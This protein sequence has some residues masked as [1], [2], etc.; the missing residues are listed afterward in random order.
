MNTKAIALD[1]DGTLLDANN[2]IHGDLVK[3]LSE[4]RKQGI[5]LFLVTGRTRDEI[6]HILPYNFPYDG[7]VTSNGMGCYIQDQVMMQQYLNKELVNQLIHLAQEYRVYYELHS[8]ST[9]RQALKTDRKMMEALMNLPAP[10]SLKENE[11]Y[12]RKEALKSEVNWVDQLDDQDVVKIYFFSIELGKMKK[13]KQ[14]L[15][16]LK[17]SLRFSTSS[18]SIHNVEIMN[19]HVNKATGLDVLLKVFNLSGNDLMAIGD[20]ENDLPMFDMSGFSVA[21]NNAPEHVKKQAVTVTRQ[22]YDQHG[23]YLF[24][25]KKRQDGQFHD[26]L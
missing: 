26:P 25:Q 10:D 7:A 12:S 11:R 23:L 8:L 2:D 3:L 1:M 16:H 19:E 4:I 14:V 24:L 9:G 21:M 15:E 17:Q 13:W 5:K 22:P 20:G 6:K 18:S